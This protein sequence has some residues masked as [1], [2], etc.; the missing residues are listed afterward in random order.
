MCFCGPNVDLY[1]HNLLVP[2]HIINICKW[3]D[4]RPPSL[5]QG[6]VTFR[7][8]PF[9]VISY[10]SSLLS[11]V[12]KNSSPPPPPKKKSHSNKLN[13]N[14]LKFHYFL[15]LRRYRKTVNNYYQEN[16]YPENFRP[17]W[18]NFWNVADKES[19]IW[20]NPKCVL[21]GEALRIVKKH[22]TLAANF[23]RNIRYLRKGKHR[24]FRKKWRLLELILHS[25]PLC[26]H[27]RPLCPFL[28]S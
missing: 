12:I 7:D 10:D 3:M 2:G 1:I 25:V 26:A 11:V 17:A 6:H 27:S 16:R 9:R 4:S 23:F 20:Q 8:A 14:P 18:W 15:E 22:L 13:V 28:F 21:K 24:R 5:Y 19:K